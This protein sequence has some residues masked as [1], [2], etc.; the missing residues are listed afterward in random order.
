[1]VSR[2]VLLT[3]LKGSVILAVKTM[4]FYF[5]LD[6]SISVVGCLALKNLNHRLFHLFLFYS[7][8]F[9]LCFFITD[10]LIISII[11][12]PFFYLFFY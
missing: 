3:T 11:L 1:M 8:V 6:Y 4:L 2:S 9:V 12:R 7:I 10:S 5:T